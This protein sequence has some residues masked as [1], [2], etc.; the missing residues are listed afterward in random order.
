MVA[1]DDS[2]VLGEPGIEDY[3]TSDVILGLLAIP[4]AG[5]LRI[6]SALL[7]AG[8][9]ELC[10]YWWRDSYSGQQHAELRDPVLVKAAFNDA[11]LDSGYLPSG[12]IRLG[13]SRNVRWLAVHVPPATYTLTLH[14]DRKKTKPRALTV[15]LPGF[16]LCGYGNQYWIWAVKERQISARTPVFRYPLPNVGGDGTMCFG[17]NQ[18]PQ[19][20]GPTIMQAMQLFFDSPFNDHWAEAKAIGHPGDIRT[21]LQQLAG[22]GA[23]ARGKRPPA[24]FP[25]EDLVPL[26]AFGTPQQELTVEH[27]FKHVLARR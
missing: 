12:V 4:E 21:Y 7:F 26:T 20:D 24:V 27:L 6:S 5:L 18:P 8:N 17:A 19:A 22:A 14:D 9:N 23:K 13:I 10:A 25:E 11:F 15:G 16:V 2:H 1:E 3:I